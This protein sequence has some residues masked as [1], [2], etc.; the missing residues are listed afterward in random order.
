MSTTIKKNDFF[1]S[2]T[3]HKDAVE[4]WYS[5]EGQL[6]C[7][8]YESGDYLIV[9]STIAGVDPKDIDISVAHD[10]LT[11]R[12]V[13]KM[14]EEIEDEKF[15][16]RECYWGSFSRSIVLPHEIDQKK[17]AAS[18]KNGVLTV[19]LPKKYKSTSIKIRQSN[20]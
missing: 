10:V 19:K 1:Q 14:D 3:D 15:Y 9:K 13:R 4:E 6:L 20:G 5:G 16:A 8:V 11:I 12:G 18:L 17:V 2:Q 7:D